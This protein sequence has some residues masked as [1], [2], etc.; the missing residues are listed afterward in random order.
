LKTF[1]LTY[2]D[3][4]KTGICVPFRKLSDINFLKRKFVKNESGVFVAPL[5][6]ETVRDMCNWVR[7][8]EIRSATIE[9]VGNALLEFALHG[10]G[11]YNF[12]SNLINKALKA[13]RLH[14]RIPLYEEFESFFLTQRKQQ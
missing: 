10:P 9:N 11:T 3:E 1:G 12:E 5:I 6:V 7:G 13:K 14:L 8:K 4:A 2:T